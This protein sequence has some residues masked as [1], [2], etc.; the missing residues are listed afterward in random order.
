MPAERAQDTHAFKQFIDHQL[1]TDPLLTVDQMIAC[2]RGET[3]SDERATTVQSIG[4]NTEKAVEEIRK[5]F[6]FITDGRNLQ[7]NPEAWSKHVK[8]WVDS[9]PHRYGPSTM[10]DSRES[11]YAGRGE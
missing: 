11:I 2:W 9:Q 3:Q 6:G 1:A 4:A 7:S 8:S 5:K 10:D